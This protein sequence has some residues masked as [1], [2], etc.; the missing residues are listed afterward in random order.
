MNV[1][2]INVNIEMDNMVANS[3]IVLPTTVETVIPT[4]TVMKMSED[5]YNYLNNVR[6]GWSRRRPMESIEA[7]IESEKRRLK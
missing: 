5:K 2:I 6:P 1:D 4:R 3:A 7:E